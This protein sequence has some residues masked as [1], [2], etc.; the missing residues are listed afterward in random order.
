MKELTVN[1]IE[2]VNGGNCLYAGQEYSTGSKLEQAGE[3]LTCQSDGL[4]G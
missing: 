4:W 3:V 2:Q 1:E